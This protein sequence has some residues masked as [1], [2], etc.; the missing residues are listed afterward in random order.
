MF[1]KI[2][3]IIFKKV[4]TLLTK[5][6]WPQMNADKKRGVHTPYVIGL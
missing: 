2:G 5:A 6:K 3:D 1:V 4:V